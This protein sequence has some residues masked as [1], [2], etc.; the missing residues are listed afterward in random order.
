MAFRSLQFEDIHDSVTKSEFKV[1]LKRCNGFKPSQQELDVLVDALDIDG[2]GT[3]C[4]REFAAAMND[5]R[6]ISIDMQG[7]TKSNIVR[8]QKKTPKAQPE[9]DAQQILAT[10]HRGGI[11]R[12]SSIRQSARPPSSGVTPPWLPLGASC[13]LPTL[14]HMQSRSPWQ[15]TSQRPIAECSPRKLLSPSMKAKCEYRL[16]REGEIKA[17]QEKGIQRDKVIEDA[18]LEKCYASLC[19]YMKKINKVEKKN[20]S[21][22]GGYGTTR[23]HFHGKRAEDSQVSIFG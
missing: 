17:D 6:G 9:V 11:M 14:Q 21:L 8:L 15:T 20:F 18:R 12:E 10:L 22:G 4:F 7:A 5:S 16:K 2:D 1:A 13:K 19:R 3:I 23:R